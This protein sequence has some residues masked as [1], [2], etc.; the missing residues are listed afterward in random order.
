MSAAKLRIGEILLQEG[1]INQGQ[2]DEALLLQKEEGGHLG[3]ILVK[4]GYV[5][6]GLMAEFLARQTADVITR[7]KKE[8]DEVRANNPL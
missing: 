7:F 8:F 1:V 2:L 4:K 5:N 6:P 3:A